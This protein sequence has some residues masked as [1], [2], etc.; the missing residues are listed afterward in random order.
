MAVFKDSL[1]NISLAIAATGAVV[2]YLNLIRTFGNNVVEHVKNRAPIYWELQIK[3]VV[4]F[5]KG[6][7]FFTYLRKYA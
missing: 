7:I 4:A 3:V 1:A 5:M 6:Y 2:G